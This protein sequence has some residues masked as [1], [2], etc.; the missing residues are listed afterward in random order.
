MIR[1]PAVVYTAQRAAAPSVS[2]SPTRLAPSDSSWLA[3]TTIATPANE[4]IAPAT[5]GPDRTSMPTAPASSATNTGEAAMRSAESPAVIWVS[6]TVHRTWYAPNPS[7]PMRNSWRPCPC[8]KRMAP[9]RQRRMSRRV[10]A[11]RPYRSAV[12]V[13]GPRT[14]I[15]ALT[16]TKFADQMRTVTR[17]PISARRR[18]RAVAR[19][20]RWGGSGR[21]EDGLSLSFVS[22]R[23]R[24][25]LL[26]VYWVIW[27]PVTVRRRPRDSDCAPARPDVDL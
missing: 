15:V 20:W 13:S 26:V 4:I 10:P 7:A 8:G 6:P 18:S 23:V 12:N 3:A 17:T 21:G 27:R 14:P 22:T 16:T 25:H 1:A 2:A 19:A 24:E 11:A 9:W 5:F